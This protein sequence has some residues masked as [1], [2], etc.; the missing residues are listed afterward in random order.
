MVLEEDAVDDGADGFLFVKLWDIRLQ[1]ARFMRRAELLAACV[2]G[3]LVMAITAFEIG[4]YR[5]VPTGYSSCRR[6]TESSSG[7]LWGNAP[8]GSEVQQS[9]DLACGP[10]DVEFVRYPRL[11]LSDV[12]HEIRIVQPCPA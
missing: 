10:C 8:V 5:F 1:Q 11:V 4:F 9:S 7:S 6:T 3:F 2:V 12:R